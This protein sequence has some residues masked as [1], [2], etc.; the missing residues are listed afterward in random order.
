MG[1]SPVSVSLSVCVSVLAQSL[2]NH[3]C[4]G[5]CQTAHVFTPNLSPTALG[6]LR[7]FL[8]THL[9][10]LLHLLPL[11][12]LRSLPSTPF[13]CP[14]FGEEGLTERETPCITAQIWESVGPG[15]KPQPRETLVTP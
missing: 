3:V 11:R 12:R 7:L 14:L 13:P 6:R 15:D 10:L 8:V 9:L 1:D 5:H 2:V 4:W